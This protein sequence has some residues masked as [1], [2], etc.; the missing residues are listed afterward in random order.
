M[1]FLV[2]FQFIAILASI[3]VISSISV[4]GQINTPCTASMISS[5]TPCINFI[6][7]STNNGSSPTQSCCS[8]LLSMTSGSMD[9]ICLVIT[10]NVPFPL[11]VNRTLAISLPQA[12]NMSGVPLQCKA[13]GSP[14][15]AP[16]PVFLG[17]TLPPPAFS[18]FSPQASKVSATAAAAAPD[19]TETA[20]A[21]A[22]DKTEA[23]T[24]LSPSSTPVVSPP[25]VDQ[26]EPPT[27]TPGIRPV[28]TPSA[29][30]LSY[31][32]P[33]SFVQIIIGI[34]VFKSY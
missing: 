26:S 4:N 8:S 20:A 2:V 9:C 24:R 3:I 15:P 21:A 28:L 22:P 11:P 18:P 16:G 17:P 25:A 23:N 29:S 19:I 6:T 13:T 12:C 31:I 34:L 27:K 33:S 32:S 30:T 7:G 14:L 5:F 10:A 1:K